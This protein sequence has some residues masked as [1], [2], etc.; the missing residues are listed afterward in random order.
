MGLDNLIRFGG[1]RS[2]LR[3]LYPSCFC[4]V[5]PSSGWDSF[6]R[7]S[8]E[9]AASGLPVVASRLH[10]LPEAV[11]DHKTGL[12]F[13]PGNARALADCLEELLDQPEYAAHLGRAGRKR[14]ES[15]LNI[16]VQKEH[17]RAVLLKRL[18]FRVTPNPTRN[19]A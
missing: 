12:L 15:E 13:E 19:Q 5:I 17:F 18:S 1:Y 9:M 6:P 8:V 14:C 10:G 11:L 3:D 2:D 16:H 4:G 7:T